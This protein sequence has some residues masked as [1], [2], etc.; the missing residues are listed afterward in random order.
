MEEGTEKDDLLDGVLSIMACHGAIR[1]NHDMRM[2]EMN[3]LLFQLKKAGL[4]SNC[5]HGRPIFILVSY[6]EI[7]KM[8]KRVV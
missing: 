1:A 6:R 5:P 4:P 8:F 7:E 2:E 3:H